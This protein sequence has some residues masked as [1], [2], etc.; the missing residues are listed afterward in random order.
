MLP[1]GLQFSVHSAP[2][3]F[4]RELAQVL[5]GVADPG[6]LLIVP[7]CQ[8]AAMDLVATGPDVA[9]EKDALLERFARWASAVCEALS[10]RGHWG[11]Y[12]DPCSGYAMRTPNARAVYPEVDAAETLLR[13]RTADAGG[14]RVLSHPQWGTAVYPA[15][16]FARAPL[17]VL[18]GR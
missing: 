11:D 4:A 14:C 5:P 13:Y 7:T 18:L 10:A 6:S 3:A 15:S 12:V 2:R 17:E 1:N 9:A 8:R 16:V